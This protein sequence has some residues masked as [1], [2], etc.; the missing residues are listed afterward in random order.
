MASTASTTWHHS[1]G[2]PAPSSSNARPKSPRSYYGLLFDSD[3]R[4]S[5][6]LDALL[7]SIGKYIIDNV[8]DRRIRHI[9]PQKLGVFYEPFP[10][11]DIDRFLLEA[12]SKDLSNMW[13][14]MGYE[15]YIIQPNNDVHARPSVPA[16]TLAGF[17]KW[18]S[19]QLLVDPAENVPVLQKAVKEYGLRNPDT[20]EP[21]PTELPRSCLPAEPDPKTCQWEDR[22]GDELRK[23]SRRPSYADTYGAQSKT[24]PPHPHMSPPTPEPAASRY[25]ERPRYTTTYMHVP[26]SNTAPRGRSGTDPESLY[27]DGGRTMP[28]SHVPSAG[29]GYIRR[30]PERERERERDRE[31]EKEKDRGHGRGHNTKPHVRNISPKQSSRRRSFTDYNGTERPHADQGAHSVSDPHLKTTQSSMPPPPTSGGPSAPQT[32]G[33]PPMASSAAATAAAASLRPGP[34]PVPGN[35]PPPQ[36]RRTSHQKRDD[37]IEVE[38]DLESES[39]SGSDLSTSDSEDESPGGSRP[40]SNRRRVPRPPR[41]TAPRHAPPIGVD[42]NIAPEGN[43]KVFR[44]RE[45]DRER[46]KPADL[47]PGGPVSPPMASPRMRP[48]P[49]H[50]HPSPPDPRRRSQGTSHSIASKIPFVGSLGSALN[51]FIGTPDRDKTRRPHSHESRFATPRPPARRSYSDEDD[52]Y[53]SEEDYDQRRR[54]N[55]RRRADQETSFKEQETRRRRE[56][57][58]DYDRRDREERPSRHLRRPE[59][60]RRTSSHADADRAERMRAK[61][62][63]DRG[64][65]RGRGSSPG[66]RRYPPA[67]PRYG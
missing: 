37:G 39:E 6:V 25:G 14:V 54:E 65:G 15:H 58:K 7:R 38:C 4:P 44:D 56:L 23:Q 28:F 19:M 36:V 31:R 27:R 46:I 11:T 57:E 61:D 47:A 41:P 26:T 13:A 8:N 22:C 33:A 42:L 67:D 51:G 64:Y 2:G 50:G 3:K 40:I 32:S 53:T 20:G 35:A 63:Y 10:T 66:Q 30:S 24:Y 43:K 45:R 17:V 12:P 21:F 18:Q 62:L 60:T 5:K 34:A 16:L 9:T 1:N 49:P 29:R 55:M 59:P 48:A 52:E